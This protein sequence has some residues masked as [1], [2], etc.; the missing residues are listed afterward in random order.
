MKFLS[1]FF[2][3]SL[4][5]SFAV[6][7][8]IQCK[9]TELKISIAPHIQKLPSGNLSRYVELTV[10]CSNSRSLILRASDDG[11]GTEKSVTLQT[12]LTL[13]T[14]AKVNGISVTL[15]FDEKS[16]QNYSDGLAILAVTLD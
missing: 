6:A 3:L 13:L 10:N 2:V 8:Q 12:Y 4:T 7:D 5:S 9:G 14:S 16:G 11:E 1:L 15:T